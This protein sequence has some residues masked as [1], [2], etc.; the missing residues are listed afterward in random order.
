[1]SDEADKPDGKQWLDST[2]TV[3]LILGVTYLIA[4][5]TGYLIKNWP[6]APRVVQPVT[7]KHFG[8]N[9]DQVLAIAKQAV[10][11]RGELVEGIVFEEPRI[12]KDGWTIPVFLGPGIGQDRLIHISPKGKIRYLRGL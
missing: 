4:S 9:R 5:V 3:V 7:G 2:L 1:M 6:V 12:Y 11:E 8:L 10:I